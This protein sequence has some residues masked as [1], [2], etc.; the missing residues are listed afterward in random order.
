MLMV[1][2]RDYGWCLDKLDKE[3]LVLLLII[4]FLAMGDTVITGA[5]VYYFI[6]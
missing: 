6:K 2:F 3:E 1:M 4:I 5:I